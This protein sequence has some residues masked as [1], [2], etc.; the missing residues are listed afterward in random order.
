LAEFGLAWVPNVI[1]DAIGGRYQ[2]VAEIGQGGS[3]TVY[4][5][6]Q[7]GL[8]R[9]VALKL[10]HPQ[11]MEP[12]K[13][14][15][16][17]REAELGQRLRHPNTVQLIDFG[18][19]EDETPYIV[20][21]LL[22][23]QSLSAVLKREHSLSWQRVARV[24][25]Q[26]LKALM[27]AHGAGIVHRDI[28]PANIFLTS[29][30]GEPDFVKVLDFGIAKSLRWGTKAL[31][32]QGEI[33]G[34]PGYMAPEHI[35]SR[36]VTPAS[37]IYSLGLMM[38]EMLSGKKTFAG[39]SVDQIVQQVSADPVPLPAEV[40]ASPLRDVILRATQ[41]RMEL[42]Y[43]NAGEMLRD[44]ELAATQSQS[45]AGAMWVRQSVNPSSVPVSATPMS[46][47][48]PSVPVY[49]SGTMSAVNSSRAGPSPLLLVVLGALALG[50]ALALG[51]AVFA[52]LR[53]RARAD[54][55]PAIALPS[56]PPMVEI[57]PESESAKATSR[58]APSASR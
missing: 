1:G 24:A 28:K 30:A 25:T 41:K 19:H 5:A 2:V 57:T 26:V 55:A 20:F 40:L 34:T 54:V 43:Q 35:E 33:M 3:G 8:G 56:A 12:G 9:E 4:R 16:F 36:P 39:S 53:P 14:E 48:M 22:E 18:V 42:R 13:L 7:L 44:L 10:M 15:R 45:N 11:Q 21:E 37:D 47:S 58:P 23:G 29:H 46:G 6:V 27:E 52:L 32:R 38:A 17:K 51:F 31:T 50:L 49:S